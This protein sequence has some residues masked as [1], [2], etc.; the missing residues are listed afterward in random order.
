MPPHFYFMIFSDR[1]ALSSHVLFEDAQDRISIFLES[2][3]T[4]KLAILVRKLIISQLL[5]I[6]SG[7]SQ[8]C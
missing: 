7:L 4:T 5:Y 8:V 1:D 6:Q 2:A 3:D